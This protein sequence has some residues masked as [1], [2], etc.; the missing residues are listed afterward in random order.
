MLIWVRKNSPIKKIYREGKCHDLFVCGADGEWEAVLEAGAG[1]GDREGL[2]AVRQSTTRQGGLAEPRTHIPTTSHSVGPSLHAHAHHRHKIVTIQHW[3][4]SSD[5]LFQR[6]FFSFPWVFKVLLLFFPVWNWWQMQH[7]CNCKTLLTMLPLCIVKSAIMTVSTPYFTHLMHLYNHNDFG[8][9]KTFPSASAA[10]CIW[11]YLH[12]DTLIKDDE[13]GKHWNCWTSTC[14]LGT[15]RMFAGLQPSP[16]MVCLT[17]N[18]LSYSPTQLFIWLHI[19]AQFAVSGMYLC[20][21]G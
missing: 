18:R 20:T 8:D 10:L 12:A 11:C 4:T 16:R 19:P 3:K 14:S 2:A 5:T 7:F 13:H 21:F 9:L 17:K 1:G 15:L 6:G